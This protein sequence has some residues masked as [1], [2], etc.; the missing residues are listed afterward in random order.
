MAVEASAGFRSN[1]TSRTS[2][3]EPGTT[4]EIQQVS[5]V[6]CGDS[7]CVTGLY[8][9]TGQLPS[10]DCCT[11]Y[12]VEVIRQSPLLIYHL[13]AVSCLTFL[14]TYIINIFTSF[15]AGA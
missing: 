4:P 13:I 12:L 9:I 7:V 11:Q 5:V 15:N 2:V 14:Y 8:R 6:A 10:G 3:G 1:L